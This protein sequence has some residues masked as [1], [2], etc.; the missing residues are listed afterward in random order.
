VALAVA[1]DLLWVGA[2]GPHVTTTA[3]PGVSALHDGLSQLRAAWD[4]VIGRF[5]YEDVPLGR[6]GVL[7]WT[8]LAAGLVVAALWRGTTRERIA[9]VAALAL[10]VVVPIY[11]YAAVTSNEGIQTQGRHILP[12]LI[13]V[14]LL[15]GELLRRHVTDLRASAARL[16]FPIV[17]IIAAAIQLLAWW[18]N[19]RRYAV[20]LHG[21]WWFVSGAKWSPPGGWVIWAIVTA[22]VAAAVIVAAGRSIATG[23]ARARAIQPVPS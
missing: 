9:L 20:G 3:A 7:V 12:L 19:S 6:F 2:Y 18:E 5:G 14:A 4:G 21:S 17:C 1:L 23:H 10:S 8:L 13:T 16:V 15:S 22:A 11:I